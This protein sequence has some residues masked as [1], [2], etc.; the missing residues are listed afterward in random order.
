MR[1]IITLLS[2]FLFLMVSSVNGQI[3]VSQLAVGGNNDGSDWDN[4]Y[5]ELSL[6]LDAATEGDEIWIALG[7]YYPPEAIIEEVGERSDTT[8]AFIIDKDLKIYGGFVGFETSVDQR[9]PLFNPVILNG[10][11]NDDDI[12]NRFDTLKDDNAR[13]IL[14]I[15]D[16]VTDATVIDGLFIWRG[17]A[18]S[19]EGLN[20]EAGGGIY[21][22]GTPVINNCTINECFAQVGG[23]VLLLGGLDSN[24]DPVGTINMTN[25][26]IDRNGASQ[27]ASGLYAIDLAIVTIEDSKFSRNNCDATGTLVLELVDSTLIS[28]VTIRDNLASFGSGLAATEVGALHVNES[29]ISE[30]FS[31][32]LTVLIEDND[33]ALFTQSQVLNNVADSNSAG[34]LSLDGELLL[35]NS[36][37]AGNS[38]SEEEG[39]GQVGVG[40]RIECLHATIGGLTSPVILNTGDLETMNSLFYG[41]ESNLYQSFGTTTITSMGGNLCGDAS[42]DSGLT[43]ATDRSSLDPLLKDAP[44]GDYSLKATSPAIDA[45]LGSAITVDVEGVARDVNPDIGAYEY[46]LSATSQTKIPN[47]SITLLPTLAQDFVTIDW[48]DEKNRDISFQIMNMEGK[49]MMRGAVSK[50]MQQLDVQAFSTGQYQILFYAEGAVTSRSFIKL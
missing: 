43:L 48:S 50:P 24:N 11:I 6:A 49:L 26:D 28:G 25:C 10:D 15:T 9:N 5:L 17:Y 38:A 4:A 12:I 21:C 45:A 2:L 18:N 16:A 44:M 42:M 40:E 3:F 46:V 36:V 47:L 23:G 34:L 7:E 30:N 20:A 27:F 35:I 37:V 22:E 39:F 13:H 41:A 29:R 19:N 1:K 14:Y 33:Y 32:N 31:G 8:H